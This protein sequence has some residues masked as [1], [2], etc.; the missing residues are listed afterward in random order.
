MPPLSPKSRTLRGKV[1]AHSRW[2][3]EDP[4]P[5][6]AKKRLAFDQRFL[7]EVDPD[8]TLPEAERLRR[9]QSAR[10]AYFARLAL[11]SAEARRSRRNA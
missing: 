11:Q 7:D 10:K 1:A 4:T 6:T 8:R 3:H 2:A 9:A 5:Q